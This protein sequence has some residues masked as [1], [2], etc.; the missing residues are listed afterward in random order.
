MRWIYENSR[1][2]QDTAMLHDCIMNSLSK[3]GK[4]KL[5]I[6]DDLY[7]FGRRQAEVCLLKVQIRKS[8]LDSNAT[9]SMIRIKLANLDEYIVQVKNV[10]AKFNNYVKVLIE[11]LNARG[12][13][14]HD[15]ITTLFQAY[16][17]Y[18]H[19]NFVKYIS[20]IQWE[21]NQKPFT[22][23]QLMD[24]AGTKYRLLK[25]KGNWKAPTPQD[26][27]IIALKAKA[28]EAKWRWSQKGNE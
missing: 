11:T 2:A 27:K 12:E 19:Q 4:A 23:T 5:I 8:Y 18:S 26:E 21:D 22:A 1:K 3:E 14:S 13:T 15:L 17:A 25:T 24:K 10:I 7:K 28:L 16:D 20:D 6:N 9:S